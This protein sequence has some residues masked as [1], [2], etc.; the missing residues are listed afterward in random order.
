MLQ[1]QIDSHFFRENPR[2]RGWAFNALFKKLLKNS[3]LR[4]F[5]SREED[6]NRSFI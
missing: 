1:S 2:G 6:G 4:N 5:F 3:L